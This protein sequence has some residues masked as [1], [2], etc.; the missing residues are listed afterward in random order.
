MSSWQLLITQYVQEHE[1][2]QQK[3]K[4]LIQLLLLEFPDITKFMENAPLIE[5]R[6]REGLSDKEKEAMVFDLSPSTKNTTI[7]QE[8][9]EM[10]KLKA[11]TK[12][13]ISYYMSKIENALFPNKAK[14]RNNERILEIGE[15]ERSI[16]LLNDEKEDEN[17]DTAETNTNK[18]KRK[19]RDLDE[20]GIQRLVDKYAKYFPPDF[21]VMGY[22][23]MAWNGNIPTRCGVFQYENEGG[24]IFLYI[25]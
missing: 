9:K 3:F 7:T 10:K 2:S 4:R 11:K 18:P 25:G 22:C 12:K 24:I 5:V 20:Q 21:D 1:T 14:K 19:K 13:K 6:I 17:I 15:L 8:E 16:Y 23:T